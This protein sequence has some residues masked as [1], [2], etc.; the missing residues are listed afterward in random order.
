M[1]KG[2]ISLVLSL[3]IVFQGVSHS[4]PA[5]AAS[6]SVS[7]GRS[8]QLKYSGQLSSISATVC[9]NQIWKLITKP[10][11]PAKP[12][13]YTKPRKYKN[14]FTVV[15]D[16]PAISNLTGVN[17]SIGQSANFMSLA[18]RHT[19]NRL[20]LWYPA[21]VRFV[22]KTFTWNFGDGVTGFGSNPSHL[23]KKLGT[24]SVKALIGYSVKYRIIGHTGWIALPGLVRAYSSPLT[25]KVGASSQPK[26][27]NVVL[28][29]WSCNEKPLA[30]GC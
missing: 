20:L 30:A 9:G 2:F 22:P 3:A 23:W 12:R 6:C 19:R 29:H 5:E 14:N 7:G 27:G 21:Q 1:V 25:V 13:K 26:L 10:K 11:K 17:L 28:V 8:G 16:K 15:P 4:Q 24:Y 18:R